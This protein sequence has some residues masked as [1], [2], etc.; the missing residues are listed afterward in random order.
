MYLG[1]EF[2]IALEQWGTLFSLVIFITLVLNR[3]KNSKEQ[4]Y[5]SIL[6]L[7]NSLMLMS[8]VLAWQFDGDVSRFGYYMVRIT[9]FAVFELNV[10]LML[11]FAAYA[12]L[13]IKRTERAIWGTS[14][15]YLLCAVATLLIVLNQFVPF[16][17][18]F[19]SANCYFRAAWFPLS[20]VPMI[21]AMLIEV[22]ILTTHR[23]EMSNER[24]MALISYIVLPLL[25][26]IL[27]SMMP[28]LSLTII[29]T[30]ISVFIAYAVSLHEK[31]QIIMEQ[32][33]SLHD[34]QLKIFMSQIKPHFLYNCLNTI[35][36]L[37]R[38]DPEQAREAIS[39]FSDYLRC[40][41]NSLTKEGL[42]PFETEM[43]HVRSY[44]SLEK[45]R[46]QEELSVEYDI[47][48]SDFLVPSLTIEPLVEN[49]V[50]HGLGKKTGGGTVRIST[51]DQDGCYKVIVEDN[52]VGFE[53][54]NESRWKED[55]VGIRNVKSRLKMMCDGI[56]LT[57]SAPGK[58]TTM[59]V[60][61][62]KE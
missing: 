4:N 24:F 10:I 46:F 26:T 37:C 57:E 34:M 33:K 59:T 44:L 8:D 30:T 41:M 47:A 62:K 58:G 49:A 9:N 28:E 21:A 3:E 50:K 56:L 32:E 22:I 61:L 60:I 12:L 15:V 29:S 13:F 36:I 18:Y 1:N 5:L 38:R 23:K 16:Y 14:L 48:V 52:G 51:R 54:G 53:P 31:N 40:N 11:L 20:H 19:D 17:Y 6:V 35:Y 42:V 43:N 45:M 55:H 2:S 39:D 27:Q 25:A 7:A